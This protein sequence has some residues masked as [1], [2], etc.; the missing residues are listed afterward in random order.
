MKSI[1]LIVLAVT[2]LTS[3]AQSVLIPGKKSFEN[4]W[5]GNTSYEMA[6]YAIKDT[7]KFE[8]GK[9]STQ[10][11]KDK[12]SVTVITQVSMKNMNHSW[13]D[14][15]IAG[16]SNLKP[17]YHSSYNKQR[18]MVLHFGKIVTGF[19]NDKIKKIYTS[20]NDTTKTEYFDS[21]LY[22]TLIGWLPLKDGYKQDISIYDYNP[23]GK[24]GVLKASLKE[25]K[26]G[27]YES[28]AGRI[29]NVWIVTMSDEIGDD[30]NVSTYY[31]DKIDR[32]LWK[33]EINAGG[34]KMVMQLIE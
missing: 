4:K 24:I 25:V 17:I 18:D 9:I 28:A 27:T 8:I 20:I 23:S 21:N 1:I 6:W 19:Y 10:I 14:S 26:S 34:R 2:T 29:R 33:Q 31:F 7:S 3:D 13:I 30:G 22:P 15:T 12:N 32:K 11:V 16:I 5:I